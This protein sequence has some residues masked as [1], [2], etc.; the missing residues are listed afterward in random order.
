MLGA[1]SLML[2]LHLVFLICAVAAMALTGLAALRLGG[3]E[4]AAEAMHWGEFVRRLVPIF[5]VASLGLIGT[6]AY[7]TSEA[8]SWKAPWVIAGLAGLFLI[9]LLGAGVEGIRGRA[10]HHELQASGLSQ[11]ARRLL[12]DP[13]SWSAKVTTWSLLLAIIFVM[14]TKPSAA[15]C[16]AALLVAL[17]CGV[18]GA[19]PFWARRGRVR[20][21]TL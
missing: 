11:R 12:C 13:I 20:A 21:T 8:W 16:A 6:G 10:A 3:T 17:A 15:I 1:Y 5:P 7:M 2:F 4:T 9:I 18:V 19:V 14:T